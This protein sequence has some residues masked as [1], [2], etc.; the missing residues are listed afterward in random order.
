[1]GMSICIKGLIS[2]DDEKYQKHCKVLRACIDANIEE[3]PKETAEYFGCKYPEEYLFEDKLETDIIA[4]R[5]SNEHS[6]GFEIVVSEI[7]EGVQKIIFFNT[8]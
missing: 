5:Y 3:L 4:H 6:E 1:M 7:P 8:W 2:S